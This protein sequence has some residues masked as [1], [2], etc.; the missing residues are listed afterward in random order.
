[1]ESL[2]VCWLPLLRM[3]TVDSEPLEPAMSFADQLPG[4]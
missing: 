1:M 2:P 3:N 4:Y